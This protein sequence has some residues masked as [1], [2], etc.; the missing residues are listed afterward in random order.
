MKKRW[1]ILM[2]LIVIIS[3]IGVLMPETPDC[4]NLTNA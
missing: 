1:I 3:L 4:G 2:T